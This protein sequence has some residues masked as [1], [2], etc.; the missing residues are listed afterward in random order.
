[1][2]PA[3]TVGLMLVSLTCGENPAVQ[4]VLTNKGLQY[5]KH[6]GTGWIQEKLESVTLPD[7]S[8]KLRIGIIGNIDYTLSGISVTKCDLPEPSVEFYQST[9]GFK[10]SVSGLSVALTGEWRAHYG[11][12]HTSGTVSLAIFNVDVTSVVKLGNDTNRHLS[13][14]SV[15]CNAAVGGVDI[16]VHGG[17]SWIVKKVVAHFKGKIAGDIRDRICPNVEESIAVLEQ[18]L[19]AMNVSFDVNQ[20]VT[21]DLPLT[22]LPIVDASSLNLGLKGEFYSIKSPTE[23]PF[24]AKPFTVPEQPGRMLS[25]GLSEF[26]LN[27]ASYG[28]YSAGALQAVINDSMLPKFSPVHL[29]TSSMGPYVPGLPKMFPGLLMSLQVYA[30]EVPLFSF[31]PGAVYLDLRGAVKAFA[32]QPNGTQTPLFKL[33]VDSLFSSKVWIADGQLKGSMALN[34]LTVT[35]VSSEVGTVKTDAIQ[36]ILW[37]ASSF[38]MIQVNRILAK[39]VT[40]PRMKQAELVNT[41]LEVDKGF[42]AVFS[43][44][45]VLMTD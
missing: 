31:L 23:P 12:I 3:V 20:V 40:L 6:V 24:Q 44:A 26:T 25:V 29:N 39:G 35:L 27:S 9:T 22:G 7:I 16:Q 18:H 32:I 34:N 42:I 37:K 28:Y 17:P 36:N 15:S 33:N 1:M 11:I 13:V 5:G 41:V 2:L 21:L 10:T 30:R 38:A 14:S 45:Q 19:Q 43:D 8:G 4:V